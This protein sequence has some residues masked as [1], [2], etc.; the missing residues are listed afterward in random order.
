[1]SRLMKGRTSFMIAHRFGTLENCDL[2]VELHEGRLTE[3][4]AAGGTAEPL[5]AVGT[6]A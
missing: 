6:E 5:E 3:A 4:R 1:M 2:F